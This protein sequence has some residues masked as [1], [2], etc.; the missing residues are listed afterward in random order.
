MRK[1]DGRFGLGPALIHL[2]NAALAGTDVRKVAL[3]LLQK[4]TLNGENLH[5]AV[6]CDGALACSPSS[7]SRTAPTRCAPCRRPAS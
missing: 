5:L 3:P 1:N 4:L 6:P 2:G 7:P